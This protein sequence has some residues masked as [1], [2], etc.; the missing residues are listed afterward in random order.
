MFGHAVKFV[1]PATLAAAV[2]TLAIGLTAAPLAS[3]VD[4]QILVGAWSGPAAIGDTGECGGASAV[5]AFSP[6]GGYRYVAVYEDCGT[7]VMIDGRY[8]LQADGG[9]LQLSMDECGDTGCP[10][11][12]STLTAS[13]SAVDPDTIVL[14]GRYTYQRQHG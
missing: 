3:A 8:E 14:D 6:N 13:I 9:V 12:P 10:P 1:A 11:G 5:F 7:T 2:A 4:A